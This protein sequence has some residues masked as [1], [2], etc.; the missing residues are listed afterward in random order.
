MSVVIL[1]WELCSLL[2][3][4]YL[5]VSRICHIKIIDLNQF[6]EESIYNIIPR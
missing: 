5:L 3:F 4:I 2:D 1:Y 6:M